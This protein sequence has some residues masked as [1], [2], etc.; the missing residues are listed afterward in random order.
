MSDRSHIVSMTWNPLRVLMM[1]RAWWRIVRDT[2]R[3]DE[4]FALADSLA[5]PTV[6]G[7]IVDA[8][9][10]TPEG[11]HALETRPRLGPLDL[12]SLRRLPPNTF[13]RA[14][15]DH[16]DGN[17]LDPNALPTRPA[18]DE[19]TYVQA[20]LFETHDVWH[21]LTG[22]GADVAGELGL[23]A[24]YLAQF[25][26]RLSAA[27]LSAGLANTMLFAFDDRDRRMDAIV[28]GWTLGRR[29][30][31]VLGVDWS[32]LWTADLGD[33]RRSFGV[34]VDGV[35]HAPLRAEGARAA[36]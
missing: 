29:A 26:A 4:V 34:D 8:F 5:S 13:G 30:R 10:Q 31:S 27:I 9:R 15:V 1:G 19:A 12:P 3:L 17:G 11:A 14:F 33:V 16:L 22:F 18:D 2:S 21:A 35:D 24:F 36:A 32:K 6:L 28:R 23:Q 25:P 7:M 20:H